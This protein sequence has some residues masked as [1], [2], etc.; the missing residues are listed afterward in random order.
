MPHVNLSEYARH[1][2]FEPTPRLPSDPDYSF[3]SAPCRNSTCPSC[4]GSCHM[5]ASGVHAA[6]RMHLTLHAALLSLSH[7][8]KPVA[9]LLGTSMAGGKAGG[10]PR[11]PVRLL[12]E[13][14]VALACRPVAVTHAAQLL[15]P[16]AACAPAGEPSASFARI[17]L[18]AAASAARK[19]QL[20]TPEETS[21]TQIREALGAAVGDSAVRS[22]S[23]DGS[24]IQRRSTSQPVPLSTATLL[25]GGPT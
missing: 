12:V 22:R 6:A 10:I 13:T 18:D 14:N 4:R 15:Q 5:R 20:R 17:R 2:S 11:G 7:A 24:P 25:A 21:L 9:A 1:Q 19:L 8:G 23:H 3:Y 16:S